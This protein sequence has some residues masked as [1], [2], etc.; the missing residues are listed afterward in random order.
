MYL[1][2]FKQM[3]IRYKFH[4]GRCMSVATWLGRGCAQKEGDDWEGWGIP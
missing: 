2:S 4:I 1:L 3:N